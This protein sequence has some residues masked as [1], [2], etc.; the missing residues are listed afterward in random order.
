M[1]QLFEMMVRSLRPLAADGGDQVLGDAAQ[2]EAAGHQR[3]AVG[4]VG[5]RLVGAG[6]GLVHLDVND[7]LSPTGACDTRRAIRIMPIVTFTT[8]FGVGD[9]YAGAMKGVVLSLAPAAQL[10]DITHGVPPM[11]VAAGAVALAQAAPLFPPGTIH[12]AVVDP[13]VGGT[14][15]DMLVESGGSLFVGPDNGV[16]SLA[17]RA[18]RRV[19][20]IESSLFRREP[21]SPTFHGRDVFAPTAGR[22]A[23]GAAAADAGPSIDAMVE[24]GSPPLHKQGGV[25]EGQVIHVDSFGNLI[26]SLPAELFAGSGAPARRGPGRGGGRGRAL[27]PGLRANVL[28]RS[29]GRADRLHRLRRPAGDR[30]PRRVRGGANGRRAGDARA[31]DPH[32]VAVPTWLRSSRP[33]RGVGRFGL[34]RC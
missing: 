17:A 16:L 30:A 2:A 24:L 3:R 5:D 22:L 13:G 15:A 28:G 26:T 1:P 19:Y 10:V 11:D 12:I 27:P 29:V 23:A 18:P 8:D 33:F 34:R 21:V 32:H 14:R 6:N 9:G 4:E 31:C 20:R 25:V 7:N